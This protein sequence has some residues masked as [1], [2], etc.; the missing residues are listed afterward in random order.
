MLELYAMFS[1]RLP[2]DTSMSRDG[3]LLSVGLCVANGTAAT[4]FPCSA[5]SIASGLAPLMPCLC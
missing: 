5:T 1:H 3:D 2:G 4:P